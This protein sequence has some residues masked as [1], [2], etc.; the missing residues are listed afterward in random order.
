M[1]GGTRGNHWGGV[2]GHC[3]G[4]GGGGEN[5]TLREEPLA[6]CDARTPRL[7]GMPGLLPSQKA[8]LGDQETYL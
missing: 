7:L 1:E 4:P 3:T 2:K 8:R 6:R 5:P